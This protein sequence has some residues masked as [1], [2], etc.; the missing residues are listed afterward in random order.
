MSS[1]LESV[2]WGKPALA[3]LKHCKDLDPKRPALM[4]IRH[5]ERPPIHSR[6]EGGATLT[7]TGIKA[8]HEFGA[9]LPGDR[10]YRLYHSSSARTIE[11]VEHIN[12]GL[13]GK[14][15][16]SRLYGVMPFRPQNQQEQFW[17][18]I[19]RDWI[20]GG[21]GLAFFV[22]WVGGRYP[23]SEMEPTL[24]FAMRAAAKTMDNLRQADAGMD[25]YV[26]HYMWVALMLFH[27]FGGI[28]PLDYRVMFMDGF[29]LQLAE[30]RMRVY[31]K[32]GKKEA[33]YPHW[34]NF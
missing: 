19:T 8:A 32:Y 30:E 2:E 25:I 16:R 27:W 34:W 28:L 18:Y 33:Y 20:E 13:V 29:I 26:S 1:I 3:L 23:S 4:H 6:E 15:A 17:D 11:T 12:R 5:S 14:N 9:R 7:E 10:S 24:Q 22:N 21:G 31:T